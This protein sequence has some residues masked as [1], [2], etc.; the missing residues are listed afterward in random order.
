M[1]NYD[2]PS[3][4]F[5][6][7][8]RPPHYSR[9]VDGVDA[10]GGR[11][12]VDWFEVISENFMVDGGRPLQVLEAVRRDF[13]IVMH[14]VSLSIGSVDP[15]DRHYL[16]R[17]KQLASRF[18]PAWISDHLCW[19]GIDRRN[20]HD[21]MPIPYTEEA[22]DHV[23]TRIREVQEILGRRIAIENISSYMTYRASA[24]PEWEFLSAIAGQADCGILLDLNNI[25]VTAYNQG[26]DPVRYI[27]SL[28][29]ERVRQFHLAGY[30]DHDGYLLDTHDHQISAPVWNL[31]DH[32]VRRFGRISTLIE[33]DDRIPEFEL[34]AAVADKARLR[35]ESA[36]G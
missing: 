2:F 3:L 13:P 7:G 33:W 5:G 12:P 21:L 4:G 19:T 16:S 9:I 36:L 27:D 22:L 32:A 15:L 35:A 8:L 31:Y 10:A 23:V 6:V 11:A 24:I 28:P 14:G 25:Y 17:L 29:V 30:S 1:R 26:F 20:L 18:D 34:L